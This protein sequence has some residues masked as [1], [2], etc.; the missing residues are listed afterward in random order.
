MEDKKL[1]NKGDIVRYDSSGV[2]KVHLRLTKVVAFNDIVK[3]E[4]GSDENR[5]IIL[6]PHGWT[7]GSQP[8]KGPLSLKV[9]ESLSKNNLAITYCFALESELTKA[10]VLN[11][12]TET[13][14]KKSL[15]LNQYAILYLLYTKNYN[16]L[17]NL[18]KDGKGYEKDV[19]NLINRRYLLSDLRYDD[20]SKTFF[21]K[22]KTKEI[23][24][25]DDSLFWE[26]FST[27]PIKV[28]GR[29][30]G[31]RKLRSTGI[32]ALETKNL[33]KKYESI[34]KDRNSVHKHIMR[35]LEAEL[36][37]RK[38]ENTLQYMQG[39]SVYLNQNSWTRY[40]DVVE[41]MDQRKIVENYGEKLI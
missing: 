23:F 33:K 6:H 22:K 14:I 37:I 7:L 4:D 2:M 19:Q 34:V 11:I 27:Y 9:R 39:M 30:G 17:S 35:C 41:Q 26:F 5:Y 28:P 32:D 31:T 38:K 25:V 20:I 36:L 12:E 24:S 16:T 13:L 29:N 21:D 15:T 8:I 18:I 1:F 10:N 40:E 3:K